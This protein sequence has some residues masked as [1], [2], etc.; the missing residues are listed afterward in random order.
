MVVRDLERKKFLL[1]F[2]PLLISFPAYFSLPH[3]TASLANS[4]TTVTVFSVADAYVNSSSSDTNY[5]DVGYLYVSAISEQDFM[6][7]MFNLS[8]IPSNANITSA[9]LK[10]YLSSTGGQIYWLPADKI[11]AY[12]CSD[13]SWTELGI[14]WNNKPSFNPEPTDTF[15]FPVVWLEKV[16]KSWNVTEDVR[17]ALPSGTLTE[18]LK[19]TN[20]TGNGYAIFQSREGSNKPKLEVEYATK[21]LIIETTIGGTTNPSPG[22]YNYVV[23]DTASVLAIPDENYAFD[24]WELDDVNVGSDNP[25]EI[26]MDSDHTLQAF[27]KL[28]TFNLTITATEGG[29]TEPVPG[30][31]TYTNGSLV[32][33]TAI[34]NLGYSFDYWL[35]NGENRTE[36]PITIVMDANHTV[37][38]FFVDN[39]P[40]EISGLVQEP[41]ENVPAY[42]N[43]MVT[44][45][46]TDSGSGLYNVTLW[47]SIDNGTN[48]THLTMTEISPNTYQTTILGYEYCTW[49]TYKIIAYDN[50]GNPAINDN[51]GYHYIYH[52]IPEFPS[53][54]I[55]PLFMLTAL[56][57]VAVYRRKHLM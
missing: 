33:V 8:S 38:A 12:Y 49:V 57:A 56:L 19:F 27:F 43:V 24:H 11:G 6:Y 32:D 3:V 4:S 55:L 35:L 42:Q 15:S 22:L 39:I 29:T 18:V 40:P 47:Y 31:Y 28:I 20:K 41:P 7:V 30:M 53:A 44:V 1:L 54:L 16:Y 9:T 10:L 21:S 23:G 25:I 26:L 36:N 50:N 37:E 13:S 51:H 5:G 48:W 52:V 46:V 2:I 45:N 17:T 14:T 34:P